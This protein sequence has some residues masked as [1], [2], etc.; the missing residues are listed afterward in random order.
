MRN[1]KKGEDT[2]DTKKEKANKINNI[3]SNYCYVNY[4]WCDMVLE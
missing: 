1:C 2:I 4:W 3:D